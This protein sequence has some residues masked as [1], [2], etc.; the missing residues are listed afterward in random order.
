[1]HEAS[2]QWL[3]SHGSYHR[4]YAVKWSLPR[5]G[6]GEEEEKDQDPRFQCRPNAPSI[7]GLTF[8]PR[9]DGEP[10]AVLPAEDSRTVILNLPNTMSL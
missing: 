10:L 4:K 3:I 2:S 8:E 5:R 6:G 9:A 1:M 7:C